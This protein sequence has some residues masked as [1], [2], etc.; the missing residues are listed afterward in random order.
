MSLLTTIEDHLTTLE[1]RLT[2]ASSKRPGLRAGDNRACTDDFLAATTQHVTAVTE[3]LL[4]IARKLAPA[5]GS[6]TKDYLISAKRL[7]RALV[8]A[9]AKQYGQAQNIGR[10]WDDVWAMV[11]IDLEAV[12]ALERDLVA[13][14]SATLPDVET[15]RLGE[16]VAA[17]A[18]RSPTR[19]H[20]H[21]PHR[22]VAGRMVR[23]VFSRADRVWDEFEGRVIQPLT[24][25]DVS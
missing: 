12:V 3:I 1:E 7:E 17:T 6:F 2:R 9:K 4:P 24:P 13:L 16:R 10:A 23:T 15:H 25:R 14:L 8:I 20:P 21:L 22:G 19:P 5:N 18:R 11:R